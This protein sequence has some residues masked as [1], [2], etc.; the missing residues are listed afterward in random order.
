MPLAHYPWDIVE[1][2][3]RHT[4]LGSMTQAEVGQEKRVPFDVRHLYWIHDIGL[5]SVEGKGYASFKSHQL[6]IP[7]AGACQVRL[8]DGV[9]WR[10]VELDSAAYKDKVFALWVKPGAWRE[11]AN[12]QVAAVMLVLSSEVQEDGNYIHDW[13]D[14]LVGVGRV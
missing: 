3:T 7:I 4:I 1:L 6:I 13:S 11:L 2:P 5:L 10:T 14:F 9:T 8:S 12:P